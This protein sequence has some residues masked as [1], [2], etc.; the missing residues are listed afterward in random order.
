MTRLLLI[1]LALAGAARADTGVG[2]IKGTVLFEGEPPERPQLKRDKDPYCAKTP[3]LGED[4]IVTKGKL[5]DV[6][7]RIKNGT[8]GTHAAPADPVVI[9]Q[10]ECTYAPHVVGLMAGQ[11]LVVKNSDGTFH[12]VHG[13]IRDK[14]LWNKPQ[15]AKDAD[16]SLDGGAADDVIEL[17]CD[18]HAW[19]HA[20]VVVQDSPY[21]AVTGDDGTFVIKNLPVGTYTL[22]TWHPTLGTR[23]LTVK[24]GTLARGQVTAR[25]SYKASD[26]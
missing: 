2:T 8:T 10:R 25:F 14:T 13:T 9:D 12:N 17:K 15:A 1:L 19:M 7:V 20:Y 26:M 16:L 21:F 3:K 24:I 23:T 18:V 4:I 5:R 11:K 6:V 22:E